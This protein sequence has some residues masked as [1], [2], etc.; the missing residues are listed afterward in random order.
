MSERLDAYL[1]EHSFA[2]SRERAKA[3]IKNGLV[4]VNGR[5]VTKPSAEVNV[6]DSVKAG[7]DFDYVSRGALKLLKVFELY[8]PSVKGLVC[9]D[10]GA[11]TGGFTDV[12]LR[13]GARKVYA[14][15]VGHGQLHESLKN[16]ERVVDMEG[17]NVKDLPDDAFSERI[18]FMSIDLSFISLKKVL[19]KLCTFLDDH[20]RVAVLIK[21][22]F[23]AG[24]EHV[25][26]NGIVK[27]RKAHIRVLKDLTVFFT[28]C[29][30]TVLGTDHSPVKGGSGNI[31]YIALLCNDDQP[32]HFTDIPELVDTAFSKLKESD[33]EGLYNS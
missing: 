12:M 10:I 8:S 17:M 1:V 26:K 13:K 24:K 15:D 31:E 28:E 3:M 2:K 11:S 6:G 23:E 29:G 22:Q 7:N 25:G 21:P 14:V 27:D 30:L 16:D 19:P 32:P 4:T 18:Q 5:A 20:A 9:A 33:Y